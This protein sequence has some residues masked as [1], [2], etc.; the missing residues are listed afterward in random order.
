MAGWTW[1]VLDLDA[2]PVQPDRDV[3]LGHGMSLLRKHFTAY[4]PLVTA[5][6]LG[7]AA[8]VFDTANAHLR[9]RQASGDITRLRDTALV[10]F[11]RTHAQV[12][13]A[14]LGTAAAARLANTGF[15]RAEQ[16]G[17]EL[18]AHGV[19]TAYQAATE[20]A[21]LL[22]ALGYQA[23]SPIAKARRDLGAL[24]IADGI[25]D[26]LYRSAGKHHTT[27][28]PRVTEPRQ[29]PVATPV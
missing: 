12:T 6:A 24:L 19:D 7:T 4:R 13:T 14:L 17:W 1:G 29:Q 20:L 9:H 25:H 15:D 27:Q 23:D 28:Q 8:A 21:Q 5:T 3:L 18:K 22:G 2:V 16:W 10:I 26:T 11:G